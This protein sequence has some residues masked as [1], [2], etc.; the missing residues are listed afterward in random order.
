M[1]QW[2]DVDEKGNV[3]LINKLSLDAVLRH[4]NQERK[5]TYHTKGFTEK[6]TMRKVCDIPAFMLQQEPL[7]R[8]FSRNIHA[9]PNY[10]KKC[11]RL[12]LQMNPQFKTNEGSI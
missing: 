5:E 7:L 6:R 4:A 3:T 2:L 9:D 1:Q 11:L 10:A 8:D 12:W